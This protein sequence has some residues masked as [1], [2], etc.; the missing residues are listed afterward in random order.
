M[1][2]LVGT[3]LALHSFDF[4]LLETNA[5]EYFFILALSTFSLDECLCKSFAHFLIEF[6]VLWLYMCK[7]DNLIL[8]TCQERY[9]PRL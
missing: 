1:A 7:K 4:H 5:I 9:I 8:K 2:I 3:M 6:S